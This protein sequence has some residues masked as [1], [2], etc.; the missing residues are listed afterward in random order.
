MRRWW[1]LLAVAWGCEG[2]GDVPEGTLVEV[3]PPFEAPVLTNA[4]PP[5]SYPPDLFDQ[6]VEGTVI[7]RLFVNRDGAVVPEST[8]VAEASGFPPL[9]SAAL[10][11]VPLMR[12]AP[13]RRSGEPVAAAFLQPI[14]F[15]QPDRAATGGRR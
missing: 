6:Q 4:E 7:L 8:R 2:A 10:H 9:D 12:F 13:A 1:V 14:H 5:V 11:G 3:P 15:R